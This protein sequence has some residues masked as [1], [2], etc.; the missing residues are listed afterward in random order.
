MRRA[1]N[2]T[3][4][5]RSK[6]M[7]RNKLKPLLLVG[8]LLTITCAAIVY[9]SKSNNFRLWPPPVKPVKGGIVTLSANLTQNKVLYGGN[10]LAAL[11]LIMTADEVL[12]LNQGDARNVDMVIV[13]DRSGSMQGEK[14]TDAKQAALNLLSSLS[15]GDRFG[16]VTYSDSVQRRSNLVK[17]TRANRE[18]LRSIISRISAGGA[19]N[20]GAGLQEGINGILSARN[21]GNVRKVILISDGL[22]NRGITNPI[23]L[24]NMASISVEKEFAISTVGVGTEFN[25]YLMTH[26]AD[27][28]T[29]NYYY[30]ENPSS[31]AE[32]FQKEFN[33]TRTAAATAVEIRIPLAHGVSIVNASGYPVEIKK[34]EAIIHPG[35]LL[36]G[37]SRKLFLT[38]QVPTHNERTFEIAGINAHYR[39]KGQ[40]YTVALADTFQLACV[41][42]QQEVFGSI[43]KNEWEEK[44]LKDDFNKL[45]EEVAAEIKKG[46]KKEALKRIDKY[47]GEQQSV[48]SVVGSGKVATSLDKDVKELRETV[49]DTFQGAPRAV[50]LKQKKNSKML[51]YEGYRGRRSSK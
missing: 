41:K 17:V 14:I 16:L 35:D 6:T 15:A 29:G 3:L 40:P 10:G 30:L 2:I 42:D 50:E 44:V 26:I 51:Q 7:K 11:S 36:S 21:N 23:S 28:G 9:A 46:R 49:E 48:N 43:D 45:R 27:R 4:I 25:E 33:N 24:G 39:Y 13:M 37:Q 20:L 31:F 12:D 8:C 19:T 34:N 22:A 38:L 32:V 47:Q 5:E 18:R 1:S